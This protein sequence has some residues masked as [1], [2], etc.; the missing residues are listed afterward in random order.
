[1]YLDVGIKVGKIV[2]AVG[3][4]A[5][6]TEVLAVEDSEF[7]TTMVELMLSVNHYG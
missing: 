5:L 4:S 3:A 6:L 7:Y 1:L 2:L